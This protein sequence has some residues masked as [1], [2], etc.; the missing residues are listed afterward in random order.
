VA[1]TW[2]TAASVATIVE[3]V[4][5]T[6]KARRAGMMLIGTNAQVRVGTGGSACCRRGDHMWTVRNFTVMAPA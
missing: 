3:L 4:A 6:W 2:L 5:M 1:R